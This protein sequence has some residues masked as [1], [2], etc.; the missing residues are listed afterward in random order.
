M[1][2]SEIKYDLVEYRWRGSAGLILAAETAG[3]LDKKIAI[4]AERLGGDRLSGLG[5]VYLGASF[6]AKEGACCN[7]A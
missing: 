1:S 4:V 2:T 6:A 5:V 7:I 3:N